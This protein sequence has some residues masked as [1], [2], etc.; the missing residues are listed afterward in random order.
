M[1]FT[2]ILLRDVAYL[3]FLRCCVTPLFKYSLYQLCSL[4]FREISLLGCGACKGPD[5]EMGYHVLFELNFPP[6]G[7]PKKLEFK[8][9][10]NDAL[11]IFLERSV[12]KKVFVFSN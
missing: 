5:E 3:S 2:L 1:C 10:M 12:T 8:M 4:S 11:P 9:T 6:A 7:T